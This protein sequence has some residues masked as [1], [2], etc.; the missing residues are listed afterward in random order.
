MSETVESGGMALH[1]ACSAALP[2]LGLGPTPH[3]QGGQGGQ[4]P[5]PH[6]HSIDTYNTNLANWTAVFDLLLAR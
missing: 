6:K 1:V 2:P 4:S 5:T 3:K